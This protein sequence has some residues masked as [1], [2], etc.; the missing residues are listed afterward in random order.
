[1]FNQ[2]PVPFDQIDQSTFNGNLPNGNDIVPNITLSQQMM[3]NQQVALQAIGYFRAIAQSTAQKTALHAFCYNL[4]SQ[5]R[6]QNQIFTQ[7]CQNLITFL[8]LL[9]IAKGYNTKDGIEMAC[10]RMYEAFMSMAWNEYKNAGLGP[11]VPNGMWQSLD[12]GLQLYTTI[13]Q[14]NQKYLQHGAAAFQ[15]QQFNGF[16][17]NNGSFNSNNTGGFNNGGFNNN[18]TSGGN[19]PRI[20]AGAVTGSFGNNNQRQTGMPLSGF[21]NNTN[22]T[23]SAAGGF[24]DEPIVESKPLQPVEEISSDVYSQYP[25]QDYPPINQNSGPAPTMNSNF[26]Q[27]QSQL[28]EVTDL[29]I[30][31]NIDEVVIDPTYFQP[32]GHKLNLEDLFGL[33]FNP[34]GIEIRPAH[35]SGWDIT[36]GDD[37]PYGIS[38]DPGTC[39]LFHVRFPD[40][41][42]KEKSVEWTEPMNYLRHELNTELRRRAQRPNG[43]AVETSMPISTIGGDVVTSKDLEVIKSEVGLDGPITNPIIIDGFFSGSTDLEVRDAVLD[44]LSELLE[45]EFSK[46]YPIPA[47]EYVSLNTHVLRLTEE[48]FDEIDALSKCADLARVALELKEMGEAGMDDHKYRFLAARLTKSVNRFMKENMSL[49]IDIDDYVTELPDLLDYLATN[50]GPRYVEIIKKGATDILRKAISVERT[51]AGFAVIDYTVNFQLGWNLDQ[52]ASL[53]IHS[54]KP[55]L[56]SVASHPTIL[57]SLRGMIKRQGAEN[58]DAR[59]LRLITADGAVLELIRGYLV[60]K[61]MLLK[62]VK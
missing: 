62:L 24:Y 49:N 18:G 23:S 32:V 37:M 50:K 58:I 9:I 38:V 61:A 44:T 15:Q 4:L 8:E 46:D 34:G 54:G 47:H 55:V 22:A 35:R 14:D 60:D 1:M 17:N 33:I 59:T 11:H 19:L 53:N 25:S 45:T 28:D 7:W 27:Q 36:L 39:V 43:I 10:Q 30:P 52:L 5:N 48:E 21:G 31:L 57:E 56:V 2:L 26:T 29:P 42:V 41:T 51:D 13:M 3:Q 40:G 6:F 20:N 16:N 12:K